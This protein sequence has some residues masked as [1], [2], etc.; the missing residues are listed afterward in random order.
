M[1][2]PVKI[3]SNNL[4]AARFWFAVSFVLM[5]VSVIQPIV[6]L[7]V[8]RIQEKVIVMDESGVFHV[9]P[10]AG[11]EDAE[12]LHGYISTLAVAS[13]L[14]RSPAGPDNRELLKQLY[15]EP[16]YSYALKIIEGESGE[17]IKKNIHQKAEISEINTIGTAN[18]RIISQ[19][20]GQLVRTGTFG[21]QVFS[22]SYL[23]E[24][25]LTLVRNP[26]LSTNGRLPLAVWNLKYK[27]TKHEN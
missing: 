8:S 17:F 16:A 1:I 2:N 20:K 19:V 11:L 21:G 6:L 14:D 25:V 22:E 5:L 9:A 12:K 7:K 15:I 27:A 24:T 26:N 10:V 13:F 18:G 23:F 4:L 3:F